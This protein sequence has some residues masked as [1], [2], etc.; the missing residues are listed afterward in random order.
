MRAPLSVSLSLG[1]RSRRMDC[2]VCPERFC[3]ELAGNALGQGRK[4]AEL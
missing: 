2:G 4:R 1:E 3:P